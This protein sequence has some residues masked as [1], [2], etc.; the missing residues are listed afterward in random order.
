MPLATLREYCQV[1]IP[2]K[3]PSESLINHVNSIT[4]DI[5]GFY[6]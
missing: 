6:S 4:I 2:F 3:V 1:T 5:S